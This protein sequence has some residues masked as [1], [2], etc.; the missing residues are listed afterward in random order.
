MYDRTQGKQIDTSSLL[1]AKC[2]EPKDMPTGRINECLAD[3]SDSLHRTNKLLAEIEDTVFCPRP[4]ETCSGSIE[5][6][7]PNETTVYLELSHIQVKVNDYNQRLDE[8][9]AALRGQL[10]GS[11]KLV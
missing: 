7:C 11:L 1:G 10:G 4:A 8:V 5:A 9:L 3:I 2:G 6:P